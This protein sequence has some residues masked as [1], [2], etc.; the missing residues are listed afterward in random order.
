MTAS[1]APSI[2]GLLL[3]GGRATRMDGVDKGLQLLDD[4]PLALHV[5]RRLAPQ[6]DE[7]LISA[8]RHPDRYAELGAPFDAR[9]VPDLT[10]DFPGPLAGLLAGM[11]AA[12][13]PLVACAPCD[14]PFLPADLVARL[15]TALDAQHA[16]IAMA[17]SVDAQHA[18]APQPTFALLRTSL[19]DDL[20]AR[21]T[22]GDRK[23]RAWYAR[24]K[25]V[26][27]EFRDERAFYNANSWQELAALARR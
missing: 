11:R 20:A 8:N 25:T 19:A 9:V 17:V 10:P 13:A 15:R 27:V 24:H 22:A 7:L 2:A 5:L 16:D 23:V 1:R 26:E 14:S 6:V 12:R 21:L 4:T 18:R 3:A